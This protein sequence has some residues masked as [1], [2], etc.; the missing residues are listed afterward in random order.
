[1][2]CSVVQTIPFVRKKKIIEERK[3]KIKSNEIADEEAVNQQK[4]RFLCG[5][6]GGFFF[7]FVYVCVTKWYLSS[8]FRVGNKYPF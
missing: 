6:V 3:P 8:R 1:M 5:W 4:R 2:L 7:R